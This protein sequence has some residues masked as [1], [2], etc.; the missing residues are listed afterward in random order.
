MEFSKC[1]L[2]YKI[3]ET[4]S[5]SFSPEVLVKN[6][7]IVIDSAVNEYKQAVKALYQ[8]DIIIYSE[9]TTAMPV[10]HE[11]EEGT[12]TLLPNRVIMRLSEN[13]VL[14]EDGYK[15]SYE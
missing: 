6:A 1:W 2:E 13:D 12:V 3:I 7:G 15:L 10:K 8:K 11:K 5:I 4:D 9:D 14:K